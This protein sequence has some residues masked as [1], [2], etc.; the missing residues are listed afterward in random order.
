MT[1]RPSTASRRSIT[2]FAVD[3]DI[4]LPT[5]EQLAAARSG[6]E[7]LGFRSE[8]PVSVEPR[9]PGSRVRQATFTDAIHVRSRPEDRQ[10]FED[11]A[12]RHRLS[13]GEAMTRLLDFAEAEEQR[14][15][16]TDR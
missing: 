14:R 9:R 10:R 4:P 3:A 15:L 16:E 13:K 12:Y 7:G 11:F 2:S 6:A 5:A 8:K 1:N